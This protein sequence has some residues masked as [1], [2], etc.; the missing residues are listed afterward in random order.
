MLIQFSGAAIRS[1]SFMDDMQ[2]L[3]QSI[4]VPVVKQQNF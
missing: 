2:G 3:V 1:M 4:Y